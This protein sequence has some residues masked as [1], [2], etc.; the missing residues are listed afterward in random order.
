[1]ASEPT[2]IY[3]AKMVRTMDP[4]RPEAEAVAVRGN[5]ILAVGSVEELS[6]YSGA[7]VDDRYAD[8]VLVPGFVEAHSHAG[9]GGA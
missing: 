3:P 5:R 6:G 1:M 9:S 2:V 7:V 4:A 8:N